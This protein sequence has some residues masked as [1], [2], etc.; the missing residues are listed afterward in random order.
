[1]INT[2]YLLIDGEKTGPYTQYEL[3]DMGIDASTFV[4]SPLAGEDEWQHASDL[5]EFRAYFESIGVYV[6]SA[7]N[8]AGFWW[9]LLAYV[10]DYIILA[11]FIFLLT[12]VVVTIL[13]TT[14]VMSATFDFDREDT[15]TKLI[16]N[17]I[18]IVCNIFYH[19][20]CEATRLRGSLGKLA[21]KLSVVDINGNNLT[22]RQALSRN[23]GKV[24]SAFALGI[25][26]LSV[27]W[28]P[29]KQAWHDQWAKTYVIRRQD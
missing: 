20:V 11:V 17:L 8:M 26:F 2:Y 15:E 21:L 28:D 6:P 7:E 27:L 24:A 14:G 25:G 5:P 3:I 12:M 9:R 18:G 23:I 16:T 10:L 29:N 22:F 13:I 19:S 4:L 1:M